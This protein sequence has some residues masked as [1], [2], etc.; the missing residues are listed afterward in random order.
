MLSL[1]LKHMNSDLF[2]SSVL[3]SEIAVFL[4]AKELGNTDQVLKVS[5]SSMAF[6][7]AL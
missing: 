3:S 5:L 2:F 1:T 6:S 7:Y 4:G